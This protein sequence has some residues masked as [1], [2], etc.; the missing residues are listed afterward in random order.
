M[1]EELNRHTSR[2]PDEMYY[3]THLTYMEMDAVTVPL[4]SRKDAEAEAVIYA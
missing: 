3:A 1:V 2:L 4:K